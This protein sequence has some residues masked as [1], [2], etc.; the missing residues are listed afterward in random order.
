M[1]RKPARRKKPSL[2]AFRALLAFHDQKQSVMAAARS[3]N[4]TQPV[5]SRKLRIFTRADVCGRILLAGAI[6][7]VGPGIKSDG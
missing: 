4:L 2:E 3:L 6:T 7:C 5:V 1:P